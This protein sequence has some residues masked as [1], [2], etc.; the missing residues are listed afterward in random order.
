MAKKFTITY[1]D[2]HTDTAAMTMRAM[3]KAEEV[4]A[5]EGLVASRDTINATM[6]AIYA[7]LRAQ[8]KTGDPFE[9]WLDAVDDFEPVEDDTTGKDEDPLG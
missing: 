7:D 8:G 5:K 6:H 3:C 1:T 2:G 4:M 9:T